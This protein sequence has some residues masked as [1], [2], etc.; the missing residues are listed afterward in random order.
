MVPTELHNHSDFLAFL[1]SL[2]QGFV[3]RSKGVDQTH[4]SVFP[5]S[6]TECFLGPEEKLGG[7]Y[8]LAKG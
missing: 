5:P 1:L 4:L 8:L 7:Q 3:W 2:L 6:A